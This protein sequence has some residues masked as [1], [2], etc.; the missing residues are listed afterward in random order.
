MCKIAILETFTFFASGIRAVLQGRNECDIVASATDCNGLFVQ[1]KDAKPDVIIIDVIHG[2]NSGMRTLKKVRRAYPKI[3]VLLIL[4]QQYSDCF[5]DYIR[6]GAKGFIFN[7]ASG[8]DLLEAI[9]QLKN[10][11][12]FFRKKVWDIFKSSI[13]KR[14]YHTQKEQKLT[15]RE[16]TVLKLFCHGLSYKEIGRRLNIS[17]RT[18]ETHKRNILSKLKINTTADM[19]RYAFHN[20]LLS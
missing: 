11:G 12:E 16:V 1:L 3:P 4:S 2:E 14:K 20:H 8:E 13:Q 18:V 19:V 7:D 17:P 6:L 15:D 5:E 10:G 9:E